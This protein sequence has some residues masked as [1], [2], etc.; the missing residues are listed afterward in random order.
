MIF[1]ILGLMDNTEGEA[2]WAFGKASATFK[3]CVEKTT[4]QEFDA[5]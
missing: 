4:E 2:L 1:I 3:T 5:E